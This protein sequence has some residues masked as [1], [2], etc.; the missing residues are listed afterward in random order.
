VGRF[1]GPGGPMGMLPMLRPQLGLS[2]AQKDQIRNI[3]G[4]HKDEWKALADR[5]RTAHEALNDASP[6]TPSGRQDGR[7]ERRG[8]LL[9]RFGLQ[10]PS[11]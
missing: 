9:E 6:A 8:R 7:R 10:R 5:S 1:G 3:A 2:D 11:L 4:S